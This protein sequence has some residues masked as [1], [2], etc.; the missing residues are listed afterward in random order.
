MSL[1]G[2]RILRYQNVAKWSLAIVCAG[3]SIDDP[4]DVCFAEEIPYRREVIVGACRKIEVD[5]TS[6]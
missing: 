4:K 1:S 3:R 5:V 6:R 2:E